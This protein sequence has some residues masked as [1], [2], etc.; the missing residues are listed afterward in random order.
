MIKLASDQMDKAGEHSGDVTPEIDQYGEQ[1]AD[2]NTNIEK[3]IVFSAGLTS[4]FVE[5]DE[6]SAADR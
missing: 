5:D 6:V 2:M 3:E 1:C 4:D